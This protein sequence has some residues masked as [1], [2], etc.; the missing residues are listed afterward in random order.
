MLKTSLHYVQEILLYQ[1]YLYRW[2]PFSPV[3]PLVDL[4]PMS[5][6]QE[7]INDE[8]NLIP[9]LNN[10][11][12]VSVLVNATT[13]QYIHT[14]NISGTK[15]PGVYGCSVSNNKPSSANATTTC[16]LGI[17]NDSLVICTFFFYR[18]KASCTWRIC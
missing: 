4:P 5:P 2:T 14:L 10:Y 17:I 15:L 1:V 11:T 9:V 18:F 13:A 3:Y 6:G 8:D 12:S 7:A 16:T